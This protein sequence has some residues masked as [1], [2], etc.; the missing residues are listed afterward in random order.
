MMSSS[1][2][3]YRGFVKAHENLLTEAMTRAL[4]THIGMSDTAHAE[5]MAHDITVGQL[6]SLR[7]DWVFNM[8]QSFE[9]F[10]FDGLVEM[11]P[12]PELAEMTNRCADV[13]QDESTS[14][15]FAVMYREALDDQWSW[16]E[17]YIS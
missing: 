13:L 2:L 7:D 9:T 10:V 4:R 17:Q 6:E 8:S 15:P 11:Y 1:T 12:E 3:E 16:I 5:L 14:E